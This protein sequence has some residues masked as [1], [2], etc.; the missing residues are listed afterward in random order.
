MQRVAKST[1]CDLCGLKIKHKRNIY[2]HK[3]TCHNVVH[4]IQNG[5]IT[6]KVS[7][8]CCD[9]NLLPSYYLQPFKR[10]DGKAAA[11]RSQSQ[12]TPVNVDLPMFPNWTPLNFQQASYSQ[13]ATSPY[14][15]KVEPAFV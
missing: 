7:N 8:Y 12:S 15:V 6:N 13:G 1:V 10:E 2:R 4:K 14:P 9:D 11:R 5:Q 3:R